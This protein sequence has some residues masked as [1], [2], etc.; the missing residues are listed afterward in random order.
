M[1]IW[2]VTYINIT[3]GRIHKQFEIAATYRDCL[4]QFIMYNHY[5]L[6]LSVCVV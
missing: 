1:K 6:V 2:L 3:T 5:C 4:H